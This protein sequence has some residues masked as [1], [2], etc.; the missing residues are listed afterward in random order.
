MATT[1]AYKVSTEHNI[2]PNMTVFDRF[3]DGVPSGWRVNANEGYV[4]CDT[5]ANNVELD[6]SRKIEVPVTYYYTIMHLS[7]YYNWA[8]FPLV[9]VPRDS[10]DKNYIFGGGDTAG[11]G[12]M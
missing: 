2:Y 1:Y 6:E 8:N 10:V 12:V 3:A 5:T 11:Y 9:A 4:F 7:K